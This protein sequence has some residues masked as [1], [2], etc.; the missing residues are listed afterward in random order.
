MTLDTYKPL[1]WELSTDKQ[2]NEMNIFERE[3]K[4]IRNYLE[5]HGYV[6][7]QKEDHIMVKDPVQ[8]YDGFGKRLEYNWVMVRDWLTAIRFVEARN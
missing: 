8:V 6:S 1:E 4:D 3:A 2:E 7:E 5:R